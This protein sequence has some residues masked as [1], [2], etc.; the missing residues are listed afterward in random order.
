MYRLIF[1]F[2]AEERGALLNPDADELA[3]ARYLRFYATRRLRELADKRRGG[4]HSDLW[5][6]L[7]LVMSKL[8]DGC[9][10]LALPALGSRLWGPTACPWLMDAECA[11]EHL[12]DA[13]RR[14][15]T[16][17]EGR[18]R[19]AV[20]WRNVGADELGSI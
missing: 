15:S 10:D 6:G 2:V 8:D 1:L 5:Q 19:Y 13:V 11:Y 14:I 4:P 12:L 9:P 16:I 20:N 3:K 7:R 17:E 18:T